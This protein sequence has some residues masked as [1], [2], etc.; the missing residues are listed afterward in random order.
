M[1]NGVNFAYISVFILVIIN[2]L[3]NSIIDKNIVLSN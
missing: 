3:K 1:K 2:N